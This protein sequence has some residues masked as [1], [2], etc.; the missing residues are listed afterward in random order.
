MREDLVG[1]TLNGKL[2]VLSCL[3]EG[4]AGQVFEVEHTLT[5]HRHALKVLRPELCQSSSAVARL[6]RE[7]GTASHLDLPFVAQ[8]FD[9]GRLEDGRAFVLFELVNGETLASLVERRGPLPA[10]EAVA[11]LARVAEALDAV[12]ARGVVHRDIKPANVMVAEQSPSLA[13]PE[14]KLLDFGVAKILD[15]ESGRV[16]ATGAVLGTPLYMAPEQ[17]HTDIEVSAAADRYA[18]AHVAFFMLAGEAYFERHAGRGLM[19]LISAVG[20]GLDLP[21]TAVAAARGV[22]LPRSFNGWFER[23]TLPDPSGR[24]SSSAEMIEALS[25]ALDGRSTTRHRRGLLALAAAVM[26]LPI[27]F[28]ALPSRE[29]ARPSEPTAEAETAAEAEA[30]GSSQTP[31]VLPSSEI[32]PPRVE[33]SKPNQTYTSVSASTPAASAEPSIVT[34]TAPASARPSAHTA[35]SATKPRDSIW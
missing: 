20:R 33:T 9:A 2:R 19:P 4:G 12:H 10:S 15:D 22:S 26:T 34:T 14:I 16:T 18:L 13:Q 7:A 23:A 30:A 27:V 21:P 31:L 5:R 32:T 25:R 28:V 6:V 3:G 11:L 24:F 17:A 35:R 1:E 8:T 29:R